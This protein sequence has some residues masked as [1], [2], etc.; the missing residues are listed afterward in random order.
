[1]SSVHHMLPEDEPDEYDET[2][3]SNPEKP[4][5]TAYMKSKVMAERAAWDMQKSW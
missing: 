2:C 5:A 3:W 4:D 1:M